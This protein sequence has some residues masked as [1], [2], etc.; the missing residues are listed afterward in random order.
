MVDEV[1]EKF[2]E[3]GRF[4]LLKKVYNEISWRVLFEYY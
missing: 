2:I 4:L 1:E 3:L